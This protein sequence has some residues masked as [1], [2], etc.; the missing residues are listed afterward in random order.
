MHSLYNAAQTFGL[1]KESKLREALRMQGVSTCAL[2]SSWVLALGLQYYTTALLM[3]IASKLYL[4]EKASFVR[5]RAH[6]DELRAALGDG[7]GARVKVIAKIENLEGVQNFDEILSAADGVMV[8]RGDL[9]IEIPAPKVFVAQKL[10]IQ[11]CNL[12]G[13]PAITA[14]QMLDS[15]ISNPR[16]TRAEVS[17]VANA[18]LDGSDAVMLSGE[19]AKG[20]FPRA[21]VETMAEV[22]REAEAAMDGE[23]LE[24]KQ[25]LMMPK[26]AASMEAVCAAAARTAQD[27]A[28]S[29]MLVVTE[30]GEAPALAAKYRPTVPIVAV[31]VDES[32][33][34]QCALLC[35]VIPVVVP[36][37]GPLG[38]ATSQYTTVNV[39][40]V[41]NAALDKVTKLGI[42]KSSSRA[43]V[44]HDADITDGAEL[45][46]WV[47][48]VVDL[49]GIPSGGMT[50][51]VSDSPSTWA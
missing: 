9:G 19:T 39:R 43:V 28:A 36:W 46:D 31:C 45:N 2:T 29:V 34:R 22:V 14:T 17:D 48:R 1:E 20:A 38:D 23:A 51:S 6:V 21:A 40:K 12:A 42:V 35:G 33:A 11:K 32:V 41:I 25:Q 37:R 7:P 4:F 44:L 5:K 10:M 3:A 18:I 49:A 50:V 27:Q 26:P 13:K 15:M 8:A 47:L 16:P 24:H 30:T